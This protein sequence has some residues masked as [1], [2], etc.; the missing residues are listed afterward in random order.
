M[1]TI[2]PSTPSPLTECANSNHAV[3]LA[4]VPVLRAEMH[5][6]AKSSD[7]PVPPVARSTQLSR[8]LLRLAAPRCFGL[9]G[10]LPARSATILLSATGMSVPIS[11][12]SAV[13][14][15][16]RGALWPVVRVLGEPG[17]P[18]A[19]YSSSSP[20]PEMPD[21]GRRRAIAGSSPHAMDSSR[22]TKLSLLGRRLWPAG[23][24]APPVTGVTA[25]DPAVAALVVEL[26]IW[27]RLIAT[28]VRSGEGA[29]LLLPLQ[30]PTAL[31]MVDMCCNGLQGAVFR[32]TRW[33]GA[34]QKNG[35]LF[36]SPHNTS[37]VDQLV[38]AVPTPTLAA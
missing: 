19:K 28:M 9:R 23:R 7:T 37:Q 31:A 20:Q 27:R 12:V 34:A 1:V 15:D 38:E 11:R 14:V 2:G 4:F 6:C 13:S 29:F 18:T 35:S 17:E 3:S 24:R 30:T 10:S 16:D 26:A 25:G 36:A 22:S 33:Q 5:A 8:R 32:T 21:C